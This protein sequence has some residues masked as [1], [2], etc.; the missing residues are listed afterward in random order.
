MSVKSA[1]QLTT[2]G[3]VRAALA[4]CLQRVAN[5][6]LPANDAKAVI[7]LANQITTSIA[8][9]LKQQN[10]KSMIGQKV[11]ELGALNIGEQ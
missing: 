4:D 7:G 5:G 6:E 11:S 1:T 10:M 9:E 3:K 2:T 8:V